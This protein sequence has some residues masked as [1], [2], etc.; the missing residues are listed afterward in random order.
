MSNLAIRAIFA[1]FTVWAGLARA[2]AQTPKFT[3]TH[4]FTGNADGGAFN[5]GVIFKL[6]TA[7]K[8]TKLHSFSGLDGASPG[9]GLVFDAKGTL[10][11][12]TALG[13]KF[14]LGTVFKLTNP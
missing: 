7:G 4:S 12:T 2:A 8:Y 3:V 6:D 14:G 5:K 11:G 13:G 1:A 10:Y 9:A